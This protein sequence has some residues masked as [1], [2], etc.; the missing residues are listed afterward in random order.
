M[1][2]IVTAELRE[3]LHRRFADF[4]RSRKMRLTP[5]RMAILDKAL[6][7]HVHFEIDEL[8][9]AI[10][11]EYRVC[12]ATVYNTVELLC[13]CNI[14]HK[15]FLHENQAAY[16]L[17]DDRH[18]HLI[19]L[20][21]G[22]VKEVRDE[23][24]SALFDKLKFPRF[25]ASFVSTNVYGVCARCA[26]KMRQTNNEEERGEKEESGDKV[27]LRAVNGEKLRKKHQI[28]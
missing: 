17:Y 4:I 22:S 1:K 11:S 6:D 21:C 25:K 9:K 13:E 26:R 19:C 20:N 15:H 27:E 18:F 23:N 2:S 5:E 12:R 28:P 10:E 7:L 16:E 14:F 3:H 8:Y 24:Y